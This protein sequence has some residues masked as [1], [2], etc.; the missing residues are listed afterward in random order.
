MHKKRR[1]K[2]TWTT[3]DSKFNKRIDNEI[4]RLES[5]R[6]PRVMRNGKIINPSEDITDE[7]KQLHNI[8]HVKR[9]VL[10]LNANSNRLSTGFFNTPC[11]YRLWQEDKL[12]YVGQ[13]N[14]LA[15]RIGSHLKDKVF[16]SFDIYTHI[17]NIQVRLAIEKRLIEEHRPKYNIVHCKTIKEKKP[18]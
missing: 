3:T 9:T 4:T 2:G 11:V 10:D 5:Q 17:E 8:K 16:D 13:T 12:V 18:M 1:T 7:I 14:C 15:E 6:K